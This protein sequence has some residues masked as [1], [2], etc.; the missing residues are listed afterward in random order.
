MTRSARA[1]NRAW[2]IQPYDE[3]LHCAKQLIQCV[4]GCC[5]PVRY[6]ATGLLEVV[7]YVLPSAA[8]SRSKVSACFICI[9]NEGLHDFLNSYNVFE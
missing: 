5:T 1:E 7:G 6:P 2:K 8:T 3:L 4:L 9:I